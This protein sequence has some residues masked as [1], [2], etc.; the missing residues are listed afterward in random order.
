MATV[1]IQTCKQRTDLWFVILLYGRV[2]QFYEQVLKCER[3]MIYA[4]YRMLKEL[5]EEVDK[6]VPDMNI[7]LNTIQVG[8]L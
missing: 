1:R 6:E 3:D 4:T 8:P 7:M 5:R 2:L